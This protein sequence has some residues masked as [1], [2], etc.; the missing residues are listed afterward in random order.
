ME[1]PT[2]PMQTESGGEQTSSLEEWL[3]PELLWVIWDLLPVIEW[4]KMRSLNSQWHEWWLARRKAKRE[5]SLTL[6]KLRG[7]RHHGEV[8]LL[9]TG[10]RHG[11]LKLNTLNGHVFYVAEYWDGRL[12]GKATLF[13]AS[14][15]KTHMVT[16]YRRGLRD[17]QRREYNLTGVLTSCT[18]WLEDKKH[19]WQFTYDGQ[20]GQI[21]SSVH[22]FSGRRHGA[23][24][25]KTLRSDVQLP[26]TWWFHGLPCS[27]HRD[28]LSRS[29]A[30]KAALV[31][32][33]LPPLQQDTASETPLQTEDY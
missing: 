3:P 19:G 21:R 27:D 33:P 10:K 1:Q 31:G 12:D 4:P 29:A 23:S 32:P 9:P 26:T 7:R 5:A 8:T 16:T 30:E 14:T 13:Y 18:N 20:T 17:G 11:T 28:F 24:R 6:Q 22:Y 15:S 25:Q 2:D